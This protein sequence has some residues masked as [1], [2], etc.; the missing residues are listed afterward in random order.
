MIN[1]IHTSAAHTLT[2][3]AVINE[4]QIQTNLQFMVLIDLPVTLYDLKYDKLVLKQY[5]VSSIFL[6]NKEH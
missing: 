1:L 2:D 5:C 3:F 6:E 4:T